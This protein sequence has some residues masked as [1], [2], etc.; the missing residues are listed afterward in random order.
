MRNMQWMIEV[1]G[2]DGFRIDAARHMPSMGA[3]TISTMRYY[4]TNPRLNHDGTI[5]PTYMFSEVA[6][7]N[8]VAIQ[9]YI[10]REFPNKLAIAANDTTVNGNRDAL[11]FPLFWRM[12]DE[13]DDDQQIA[14]GTTGTRSATPARI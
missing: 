3:S 9:P 10:R 8:S 13:L 4:A 1:I 7:G 14:R 6:D 11:D 2:V 5:K 12:V